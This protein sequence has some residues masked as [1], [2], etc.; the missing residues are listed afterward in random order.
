MNR[1]GNSAV[2]A[3]VE[4]EKAK[5]DVRNLMHSVVYKCSEMCIPKYDVTRL[6]RRER[7]C[8]NNCANRW[9]DTFDIVTERMYPDTSRPEIEPED[10]VA[11]AMGSSEEAE[12]SS[13]HKDE[14]ME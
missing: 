13:Q 12:S 9:F 7:A 6:S 2:Q 1:Y 8:L 14:E 10:S 11:G 5:L 3:V 4:T